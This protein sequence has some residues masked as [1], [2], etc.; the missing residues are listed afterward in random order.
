MGK[1]TRARTPR[2]PA[3]LALT[4]LAFLAGSRGVPAQSAPI[5]DL[6]HFPKATLDITSGKR[7]AH[8]DIWIADTPQ[9]EE[10]G[11]MFVRD[12]PARQGM[13]FPQSAPRPMSMWMKNTFIELDLLFID[14]TGRLSK[15]AARAVPQ[16]LDTIDSG[17]PISA[18]LEI[19]G[20]EAEKLGLHVGDHVKW[21]G[22]TQ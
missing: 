17:G 22:V 13:L 14:S 7:K 2:L 15:I 5:E 8:F 10:Q 21:S 3:H 16:S 1:P 12:L 20:G 6:S 18:V 9:R 19:K 11:L 4:A